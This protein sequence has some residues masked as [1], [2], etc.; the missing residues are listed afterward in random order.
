MPIFAVSFMDFVIQQSLPKRT[1]SI[2]W[3]RGEAQR[4]R[5]YALALLS[6][7]DF[8]P[9]LHFVPGPGA[10]HS[11]G[12]RILLPTCPSERDPPG[13]GGPCHESALPSL[14]RAPRAFLVSL[15][16]DPCFSPELRCLLLLPWVHISA[17][18]FT[19]DTPPA[20]THRCVYLYPSLR[21]KFPSPEPSRLGTREEPSEHLLGERLLWGAGRE[22]GE[23]PRWLRLVARQADFK[24]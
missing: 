4:Q 17:V 11:L 5:I 13:R 14:F 24:S 21:S 19:A 20:L 10:L 3:W 2:D 9:H 16:P 12:G 1:D 22:L 6:L 18:S 8:F 15:R 23:V 7:K